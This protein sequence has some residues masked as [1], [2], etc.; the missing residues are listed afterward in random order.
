MIQVRRVP[1]LVEVGVQ[2][3]VTDPGEAPGQDMEEE[4]ADELD[5]GEPHAATDI[6]RV[7]N[8]RMDSALLE[9]T[10]AAAEESGGQLSYDGIESLTEAVRRKTGEPVDGFLT[11]A[12]HAGLLA[13]CPWPS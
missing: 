13:P 7:N 5:C 6:I 9:S 1:V 4:H 11:N 10:M 2:A 3:V 8:G 12:L